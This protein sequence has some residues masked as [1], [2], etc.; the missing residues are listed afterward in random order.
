[1]INP[2]AQINRMYVRT[3]LQEKQPGF[4]EM[5]ESIVRELVL[6][7]MAQDSFTDHAGAASARPLRDASRRIG[8]IRPAALGGR[9]VPATHT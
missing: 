7:S 9:W 2:Q 8:A 3:L 1:M 4:A 6:E 5:L